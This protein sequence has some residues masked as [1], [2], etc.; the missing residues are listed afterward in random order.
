MDYT[1]GWQA[2]QDEQS[3]FDL[4][5]RST[6]FPACPME[7]KR[8]YRWDGDWFQPVKTEY[9]VKP[10]ATTLSF[11][12]LLVDHAISVWGPGAAI[13]IMRPI[14]PDWPPTTQ[15]DGTPFPADAH[16]EWR[17][18]AGIYQALLGEREAALRAFEEIVDS[19]AVPNSTWITRAK[20]WLN[21]YQDSQDVYRACV[22]TEHCSP[23][24][25]LSYLVGNLGRSDYPSSLNILAKRGLSLTSSGYFDFDGDHSREIWFTVRHRPGEKLELWI[26]APYSEGIKAILVDLVDSNKPALSILDQETIPPTILLNDS[27]AFSFDRL[28]GTLEPYL[29]WHEL[30]R[31][32]RNRFEEPLNTAIQDLFNGEDAATI[33]KTL[34]DLQKYPGLLCRGT[35]SC[36][37]YYYMLGLASEL[38]GDQRQAIDAYVQLWSDYSKSPFTSMARLKLAGK[39]IA[40]A[41]TQT[42]TVPTPI[43]RTITPTITPTATPT[44]TGTPPTS[45]ATPT[46]TL[47]ATPPTSYPF[48]TPFSTVGYTPYPP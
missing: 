31:F 21:T 38:A 14:L 11:C 23:A 7:L 16:D 29:T 20:G 41:V 26:L 27:K 43:T 45:T 44:I 34:L 37:K 22:N 3:G 32:Y 4:Q 42:P 33:Q 5:V 47:T 8:T 9:L 17:F 1:V 6:L 30:P 18:R 15:E 10:E 46:A 24:R 13:Q 19:P 25:A 2:V 40:L 48:E 36:D 35:W 39:S 28:P 12:R